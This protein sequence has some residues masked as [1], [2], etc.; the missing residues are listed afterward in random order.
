MLLNPSLGSGGGGGEILHLP[1]LFF[2]NNSK[3]VK[4]VTF[5]LCNIK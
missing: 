1:L 2:S 4:A 5:Q 3:K